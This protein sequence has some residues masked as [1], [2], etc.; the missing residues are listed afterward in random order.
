MS[1]KLGEKAMGGDW[2][3][4]GAQYFDMTEDITNFKVNHAIF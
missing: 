1:A 2:E 3:Q 4:I